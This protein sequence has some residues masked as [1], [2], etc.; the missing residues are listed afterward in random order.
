M[1]LAKWEKEV[2]RALEQIDAL[3]KEK[4]VDEALEQIEALQGKGRVD[5]APE[6]IH[7][8]Q[9]G[10]QDGTA[11]ERRT[12][13]RKKGRD[14]K[15]LEQRRAVQ[16]RRFRIAL[17]YPGERRKFVGRVAQHLAKS[18]GRERVLYD[19]YHEAE[20]ARP[21]LDV[22][23]QRLY[24]GK[25]DL[26]VVFLCAEYS[27]KKWCGLEWRAIR[28]LVESRRAPAV[29]LFRFDNATIPGVYPTDGCVWIRRRKAKEIGDLI[30]IRMHLN[31]QVPTTAASAAVPSALPASARPSTGPSRRR[32]P[33]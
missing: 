11:R 27:R 8:L 9:T 32:H 12:I 22:H 13:L 15:K 33:S 16:E 18:I 7:A 5:E 29:M 23:L 3:Q 2:E 17:S 31:A 24:H 6:R 28:D 4:A 20:F 14:D 21:D 25:S 26:I 10:K 1:R 30:L 19:K